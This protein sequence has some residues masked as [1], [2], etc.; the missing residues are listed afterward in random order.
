MKPITQPSSANELP[1]KVIPSPSRPIS[2]IKIPPMKVTINPGPIKYSGFSFNNFF[3]ILIKEKIIRNNYSK[4][5]CNNSENQFLCFVHN[6][7]Y[8]DSKN[9]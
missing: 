5:T 7:K 8:N 6:I 1:N 4:K 9:T 3:I 2:S